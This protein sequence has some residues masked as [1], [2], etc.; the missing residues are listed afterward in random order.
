MTY[1]HS[2]PLVYEHLEVEEKPDPR[3]Q[4]GC[5]WDQTPDSHNQAKDR[6]Q[7]QENQEAETPFQAC[8]VWNCANLQV[9]IKKLN[10][11]QNQEN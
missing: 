7:V 2:V 11:I 4:E 1:T 5:I 3:P 9:K 8:L 10:Q 6:D